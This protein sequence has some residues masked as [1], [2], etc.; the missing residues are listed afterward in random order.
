M[1]RAETSHWQCH[2]FGDICIPLTILFSVARGCVDA[3]ANWRRLFLTRIRCIHSRRHQI[4]GVFFDK[5]A[6]L[7]YILSKIHTV[8]LNKKH[9]DAV[10]A[11]GMINYKNLTVYNLQ[12]YMFYFYVLWSISIF[13]LGIP[14]WLCICSSYSRIPFGFVYV[15][16]LP[17]LN[18]L[19]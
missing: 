18:N 7:F 17:Q 3:A 15:L 8:R 13:L 1:L 16:L 14:F 9:F 12:R 10:K 6:S 11:V 2:Q 4:G 5:L 19:C